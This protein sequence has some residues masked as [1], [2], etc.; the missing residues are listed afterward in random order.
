[1]GRRLLSALREDKIEVVAFAD[2]NPALWH[3]QIAGIS[4]L[5]PEKA[6][7]EFGDRATFL[8]ALWHPCSVS[9]TR[10]ALQQLRHLGCADIAFFPEL[11]IRYKR[12]LLP[13]LFWSDPSV[14]ASH[15]REILQ[16]FDLLRD[17]AS[18]RAFLQAVRLRLL[19][20]FEGLDE[21]GTTAQY[22]PRELYRVS[23]DEF[24]V[25]CGAF[26]GD[27]VRD[28]LEESGGRFRKIVAFEADPTMAVRL[29]ASIKKL[30]MADRIDIQEKAV[31]AANGTVS[32]APNGTVG[33]SICQSGGIALPCVALDSTL[34][35]Q[36]VSL[37]KMDIEG[38]ESD[39]LHGAAET[40]RSSRP[41]LCICVY[42]RPNDLWTIPLQIHQCMPDAGLY[43]RSHRADG[44][45]LV[46]YA[47]PPERKSL[48]S[49][50][51]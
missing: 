47:I 9:A 26:D 24:F 2:N 50:R 32:F 3:S 30:G 42:H 27:T 36:P 38:A 31:G 14:L 15:S 49:H 12:R 18:R 21:P 37:V 7:Q 17:E 11:L 44:W 13:L 41:V 51:N 19:G 23:S 45:D 1:M 6:A 20:D 35:G 39:A 29:K 34:A 48:P 46:C 10:S 5:P 25:D 8:I 33:G 22:F 4:V 16:V 43:F 40:I 28:F